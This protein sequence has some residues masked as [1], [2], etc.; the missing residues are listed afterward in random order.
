[1]YEVWVVCCNALNF[2]NSYKYNY[3][4]PFNAAIF[5]KQS[6]AKEIKLKCFVAAY[7]YK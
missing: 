2:G 3:F 1:M 5:Q 6:S 4:F 7:V